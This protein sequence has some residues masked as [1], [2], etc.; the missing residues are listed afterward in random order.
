VFEDMAGRVPIAKSFLEDRNPVRTGGPMQV[1]VA[2]AKSHAGARRIPI[3]WPTRC[4]T[5]CSHAAAACTTASRTSS[6]IPASYDSLIYRYADFNAGHYASRNA[7]FQKAVSDISASRST[8][9]VTCCASRRQ[10]REGA[11]LHR[12][13]RA[14]GGEAHRHER[15][16]GAPRPRDGGELDFEKSTLY[17]GVSSCRS[18]GR[19]ACAA[20]GAAKIELKSA[21]ITR[22][23]TTDWFAKTR[24]SPAAL[25]RTWPKS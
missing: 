17:R 25:R 15:L 13:R 4:A 9:T 5:R 8:S 11:R 12:A 23:L 3:R 22:K 14:R 20:G 2:F 21:K 10:A 16:R 19:E 18:R 1:S 7:A 24:D 6:T